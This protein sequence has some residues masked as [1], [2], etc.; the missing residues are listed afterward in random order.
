MPDGDQVRY[1]IRKGDISQNVLGMCTFGELLCYVLPG[2]EG[3]AHDSRVLQA[4]LGDDLIPLPGSYYLVGATYGLRS[5]FLP[6]YR[7]VRYHLKEQHQSEQKPQNKEELFNLRHAQLRNIVERI[8]GILKRHFRILR[9]LLST[10]M[11]LK[12]SWSLPLLPCTISYGKTT[13][14]VTQNLN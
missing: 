11:L 3:S 2:W 6:A 1:R 8:F 12:S 4:A 14:R 13:M 5:S 7:G 10:L 9:A